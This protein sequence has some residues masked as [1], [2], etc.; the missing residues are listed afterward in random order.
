MKK[1]IIVAMLA[2][3]LA[4]TYIT[5]CSASTYQDSYDEAKKQV[6][7]Q[8]AEMQKEIDKKV[9]EIMNGGKQSENQTESTDDNELE[10]S[11]PHEEENPKST[12]TEKTEKEHQEKNTESKRAETTEP[13]ESFVEKYDNESVVSAKMVLDR[14]VSNYDIPLAPQLWTIAD[15]DDKGAVIA[16]AD[17]ENPSGQT[18]NTIVVLTPIM[19]DDKMTG[20]TPHYV[21]VGSTVY[22]DD[23]Y[24]NDV[25][26]KIENI[27][28]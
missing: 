24:C 26:D 1:K 21:S 14:F 15:F 7:E 27:G 28:K 20:S 8:A 6:D 5:G 19:E 10:Q 16:M 3:T 12:D 25:F 22:G 13:E 2:S 11:E 18:E 9:D 4:G 17:I 23:G